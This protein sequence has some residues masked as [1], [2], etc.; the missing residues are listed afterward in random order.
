VELHI[1]IPQVFQPLLSKVRYKGAWG[2][3]GSGKS[4]FFANQ[5]I[6]YSILNPSSRIVCIREVQRTLKESS[7][8]L[9]EDCISNLGL[10]INQGFECLTDEIRTPQGGI[11]TFLG[12]NNSNA[13]NIK[14]LEGYNIAWVEEAQTI[15]QRS[16][17]L[18]RPTIR[19]EHSQLWFSWNPRRRTDPIE[20][21]LKINTP[22]NSVVVKANYSDNPMFPSVLEQERLDCLN[23]TP[24]QYGHIWLGEYATILVGAYYAQHINTA[25]QE[26]RVGNVGPDPLL[27]YKIAVD[28]GGTGAKADSYVMWVFQ[29]VGKEA[30]ILNYY[31]AQGQPFATHAEWLRV[32]KY[33]PNNT[34]IYLPHDGVAHDK[35]YNV[36]YETSFSDIGYDVT[37]IPNQGAGAA[38]NRIEITRRMFPSCW[39]DIKTTAGIEALGWYHSKQ[40]DVRGIDLGPEHDWASH[41]ADAF[42]L[43]AIVSQDAMDNVGWKNK[44]ID[45]SRLDRQYI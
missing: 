15:S 1:K 24:E 35:I 3:R 42:G 18:L 5:A 17:D 30:R 28:I 39:F 16:L 33:T 22:S 13:D 27:P 11:I 4:H 9:L 19:A 10:G 20:Q 21:L 45:Y 29:N 8:R 34:Q 40:D 37:V 14:S 36:S 25:K 43:L 26:G 2:G 44:P 7:K 6:K 12:M 31:E 38:S 32:N 23:K 41:S